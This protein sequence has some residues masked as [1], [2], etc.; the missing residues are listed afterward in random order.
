MSAYEPVYGHRDT[1]PQRYEPENLAP[2]H[3]PKSKT[4]QLSEAY[5]ICGYVFAVFPPYAIPANDYRVSACLSATELS[6]RSPRIR[7]QASHVPRSV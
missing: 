5:R 1:I 2:T 3:S 6:A 4:I 7:I